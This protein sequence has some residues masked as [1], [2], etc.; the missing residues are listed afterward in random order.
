M[1]G[2]SSL[3]VDFDSVDKFR[4]PFIRLILESFSVLE[5]LLSFNFSFGYSLSEPVNIKVVLYY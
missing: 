1:C 5:L 4:N 3:S 2:T